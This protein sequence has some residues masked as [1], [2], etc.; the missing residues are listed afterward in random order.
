MTNIRV[1][2]ATR[3]DIERIAEFQQAMALE[4]EGRM[5]DSAVSTQGIIAIF[6]DPVKGFYI[7]A[8]ADSDDSVSDV[9]VG[10][11]LITYEWSDWSNANHWWI[12]SVYVDAEWR[13]KGVYR[14]LYEHVL[15]MTRNRSDV[16][17]IRLYVERTN[18][19]AQ[20]TYKSLGMSHSH[21]DMYEIELSGH[22]TL[23]L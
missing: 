22:S 18:T 10:S 8:V 9:V 15:S 11:L 2:N 4:T 3:S 20:Q 14:T 21:Y 7:V 6:D 17:S 5:L 23:P 13:R 19:V 12:Q 16:C 1:R